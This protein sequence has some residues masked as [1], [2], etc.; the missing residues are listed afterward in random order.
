VHREVAVGDLL[1]IF[2]KGAEAAMAW[3]REAGDD[4]AGGGVQAP[5]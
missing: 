4:A 1:H 2:P 5:R 3:T